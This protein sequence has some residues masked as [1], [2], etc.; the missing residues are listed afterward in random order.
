MDSPPTQRLRPAHDRT[1]E[2][3][4]LTPVPVTEIAQADAPLGARYQTLGLATLAVDC[5]DH[6]LA[7][8]RDALRAAELVT[9]AANLTVGRIKGDLGGHLASAGDSAEAADLL[10]SSVDLIRA[11][12]FPGSHM[13]AAAAARYIEFCD[14]AGK[15]ADAD[16]YRALVASLS[17]PA[18]R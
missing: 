2:V 17:S 10:K 18:S 9:P 3:D 5:R 6:A 8:L 1:T 16:P 14:H 12:R 13:T 11:E 15:R 7:I 4:D